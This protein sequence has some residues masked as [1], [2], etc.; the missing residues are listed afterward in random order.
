MFN[1]RKKVLFQGGEVKNSVA[2]PGSMGGIIERL[3]RW[4]VEAGGHWW[5]ED[6]G[7][8][9]G[10]QGEFVVYSWFTVEMR[11]VV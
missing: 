6:S 5:S 3:A 10:W 7:W 4:Y 8:M 9:Y 11:G 1:F 2:P